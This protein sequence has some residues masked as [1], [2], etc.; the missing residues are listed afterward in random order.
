[1]VK[2]CLFFKS[3]QK[4]SIVTFGAASALIFAVGPAVIAVTATQAA[5]IGAG[6][7]A[8]VAALS[9]RESPPPKQDGLAALAMAF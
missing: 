5:L 1:M 2:S 8:G 4:K 9:G 7:Y 6:L 3:I